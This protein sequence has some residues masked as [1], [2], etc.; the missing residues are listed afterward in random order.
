[1]DK[2]VSKYILLDRKWW[3]AAPLMLLAVVTFL[4]ETTPR[5]GAGTNSDSERTLVVDSDLIM[6]P[7]PRWFVNGPL[8]EKALEKAYTEQVRVQ[9]E[10]FLTDKRDEISRSISLSTR[11]LNHLVPILERN[12]LPGELIYLCVIESGYR[13]QARSHAGAVG[14][15]QMIRATSSRFGLKTNSWEDQRLDFI[16]ST[17]GAA[18]FLKYL[19][20]KFGDWDL[21][22]AAYNAGEGRVRSAMKKARR[23]G[24]KPEFK[25]LRLP[26][27]TRIYVP[28]FYA[29]LLIALEPERYGMF[30]D[31]QPP[32]DYYEV[33][34][35]GGVEVRTLAEELGISE[36]EIGILNPSL[37][38]GRVPPNKGGYTMRIPCSLDLAQ[39]QSVADNMNEVNWITYKVRRGDTLWDIS[40]RFGVSTGKINRGGSSRKSSLI[41]P[42]EL[43]LIPVVG[44]Q[45]SLKKAS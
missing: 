44:E 45:G 33:K 39:A 37:L 43:L 40:R 3:V 38:K 22:L 41:F 15:W 14:M 25:N 29:A 35:P 23:M 8:V 10:H 18:R 21:V 28:A 30:P 16:R 5:A 27:E 31:Y 20:A 42:G 1:M 7:K 24:L 19:H 34:L 2:R 17:E 32:M 13:Q 26:R 11:Y 9:L 36:E 6:E 4:I 12:G